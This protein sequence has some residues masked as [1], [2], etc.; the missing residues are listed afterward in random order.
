MM[1][2]GWDG[3]IGEYCVQ[4]I[5]VFFVICDDIVFG[6]VSI[7]VLLVCF[8]VIMSFILDV[9]IVVFELFGI[10]GF[11]WV[12]IFVDISGFVDFGGEVSYFGVFGE[13][14]VFYEL[15]LFNDG[16]QLL[17]GVYYF[18]FVVYGGVSGI[19]LVL[20]YSVG[21]VFIGNFIFIELFFVFDVLVV[22]EIIQDEVIFFGDNGEINVSVIGGLGSFFYEWSNGEIIVIISGFVVGDYIV[23]IIDDFGC[24]DLVEMIYIVD[25]VVGVDDVVFIIF[26]EL[27]LNFVKDQVLISY[28]FVDQSNLQFQVIN[29]IG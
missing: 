6:D 3:V 29:S 1:I 13:M 28:S 4:F 16:F 26:F 18:I 14:Q 8:G 5:Q 10:N 23:I 27:V 9:G 24:V 12:V 25:M 20:D 19:W 11:C 21:C 15:V 7:D 2:D 22:I 17:V